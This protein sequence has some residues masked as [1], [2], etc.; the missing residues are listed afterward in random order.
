MDI[1]NLI[2]SDEALSVIDSGTWV[3]AG[4]EYPGV[5]LFVTG[6]QSDAAQ[7]A[8]KQEQAQARLKNRG[9]ELSVEQLADCTKRVL[10]TVVLKD[11]KG[12][13]EGDSDIAYSRDL[14]TKWIMSRGGNRFTALVLSCA[15]KVDDMAQEFVEDATK[16]SSQD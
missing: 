2:Y 13:K 1:N 8:M 11:W 10:S 9:K 3:E 5:E 14:A 6:L 15:Q 16:K 12:L 4:D 7:K